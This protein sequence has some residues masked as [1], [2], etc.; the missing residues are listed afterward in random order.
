MGKS[1]SV[2]SPGIFETSPQK[3]ILP[4][5]QEQEHE[6]VL[7]EVKSLQVKSLDKAQVNSLDKAQMKSLDKAQVKSLLDHL[8]EEEKKGP[9]LV[10]VLV[11]I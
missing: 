9:C 5:P 3:P 10:I 2:E 11:I 1:V 6:S 4:E 7:S 8:S